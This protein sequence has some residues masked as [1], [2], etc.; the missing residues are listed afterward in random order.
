MWNGGNI[1]N[2]P[3]K[4]F[5]M[6][7]IIVILSGLLVLFVINLA[8]IYFGYSPHV[9]ATY[10]MTGGFIA[11]IVINL[12]DRIVFQKGSPREE[13]EKQER[14]K[15]ASRQKALESV[16]T[17]RLGIPIEELDLEVLI[18]MEKDLADKTAKGNKNEKTE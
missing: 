14:Q 16:V 18:Q 12:Y 3:D 17:Q 10:F 11:Y 6:K 13:R 4:N 7:M 15:I 8:S 2:K 1:M 9:V 5:F